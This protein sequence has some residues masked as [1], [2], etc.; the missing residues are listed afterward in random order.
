MS[1]KDKITEY[2]KELYC[3]YND[4]GTKAFS[5]RD[6]ASEIERKFNKKLTY[7]TVKN[8]ADKGDWNK[9]NEQI[10]Q[11]SIE[12]A[13]DDKLSTEEQLIESRSDKLAKSYQNAEKLENVGYDVFFKAFDGKEHTLIT[14]KDAISAIKLGTDIRFR[15]E[16]VPEAKQS[17]SINLENLSTDEL[18]KRAELIRKLN[19]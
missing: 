13:Q 11:Q 15:I 10:K 4:D 8:W 18:L 7:V 5:L 1:K 12:K 9:T 16:D 3:Q 6:I 19:D 14:I 17:I 2:A